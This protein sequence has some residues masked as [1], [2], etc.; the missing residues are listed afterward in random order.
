MCLSLCPAP[1]LS[2]LRR[3]LKKRTWS[4]PEKEDAVPACAELPSRNIAQAVLQERE[5]RTARRTRD[6]Q[7]FGVQEEGLLEE[8]RL[9]WILQGWV[10]CASRWREAARHQAIETARA[11]AREAGNKCGCEK[12]KKKSSFGEARSVRRGTTRG[13]VKGRECL[14]L[15]LQLVLGATMCQVLC[16]GYGWE[17]QRPR[18]CPTGSYDPTG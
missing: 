9:E 11:K 17:P 10:R 8:G 3:A 2:L 7:P 14:S 16:Q 13:Q 12:G 5:H 18:P 15:I 6:T 1:S 4:L